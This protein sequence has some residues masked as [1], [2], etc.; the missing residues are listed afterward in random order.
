MTR[1]SR[2]AKLTPPAWAET[3]NG[4]TSRRTRM[5]MPVRYLK[6]DNSEKDAHWYGD[7]AAFT[8]PVCNRI[9]LVCGHLRPNGQQCP[10]PGCGRS[11]AYVHGRLESGG[12]AVITWP[13]TPGEFPDLEK[14][15]NA[16]D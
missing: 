7:N 14:L 1:N 15:K 8:C 12:I 10:P 9:F 6:R 16:A 13:I 3:D 2:L 5:A 4:L 11:Y